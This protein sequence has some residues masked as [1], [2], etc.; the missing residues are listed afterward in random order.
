MAKRPSP[1]KCVHCLAE[2]VCRTWDHVF[3]RAWYPDTTPPVA[4]WQIPVCEPC[5]KRYGE[6]EEDLLMR[7]AL[8]VD[9]R[10]A[11]AA[12]IYQSVRRSFLPEFARDERDRQAREAKQRKLRAN[13]LEGAQIPT[14]GIYPGLGNRWGTPSETVLAITIPA[15][16][17]EKLAEKI[18]RGIL[19]I[20]D[21]RYI[22]TPYS[23]KFIALEEAAARELR[24]MFDICG[25]ERSRGPGISVKRV[26]ANDEP[27]VGLFEITIWKEFVMHAV[28]ERDEVAT[29]DDNAQP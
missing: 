20:E 19:F 2:E 18:V 28:V 9:P 25:T 8:T 4:K 3:P 1:G 24:P 7:L 15:K 29:P 12:G 14:D 23:V 11:E 21:G 22:E 6:L 13:I 26:A 16:S 10:A 5:N 17:L 27:I